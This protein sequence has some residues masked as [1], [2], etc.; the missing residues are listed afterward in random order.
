[1]TAQH[2]GQRVAHCFSNRLPYSIGNRG[3]D[4]IANLFR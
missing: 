1:M 4:Q 3:E 2:A